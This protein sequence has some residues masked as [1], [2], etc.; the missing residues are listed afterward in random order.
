MQEMGFV[1]PLDIHAEQ[2]VHP[3]P[4]DRSLHKV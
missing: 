3:K 4:K 1:R 2:V